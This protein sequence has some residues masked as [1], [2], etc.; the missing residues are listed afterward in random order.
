MM[1]VVVRH[2]GLCRAHGTAPLC[3]CALKAVQDATDAEY[4]MRIEVENLQS[5]LVGMEN[6]V[7]SLV[8]LLDPEDSRYLLSGVAE[9]V[10]RAR[11]LP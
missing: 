11:A 3:D 4:E 7:G 2:D 5:R 6:L 1:R 9:L 8:R 10:Q